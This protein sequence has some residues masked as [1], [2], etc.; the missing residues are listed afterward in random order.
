MAQYVKRYFFF[1]LMGFLTFFR[2]SSEAKAERIC[3]NTSV[4][5]ACEAA[6]YRFC[7]QDGKCYTPGAY[8]QSACYNP[9]TGS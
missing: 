6:G 5:N 9:Y 1:L 3:V 7:D 4:A 2:G 8:D